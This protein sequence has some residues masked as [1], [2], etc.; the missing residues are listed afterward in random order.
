MS[1]EYDLVVVGGG[2]AGLSAAM[3]GARSGRRV[4]IIAGGLV[5]GQ[6]VS[7]DRIEGIPGF[8]DGIAG[9][10]LCPMAQ[11]QADAAGVEFVASR[12]NSL[13]RTGSQWRLAGDD[14]DLVARALIVATGTS[15]AKLHVPGEDRLQ[16]RGVSECA[17]C[18]A[19]LLRNKIAVVVGGGDSGMQEALTLAD[20]V[21]KVLII[22]RGPALTGQKNYID[23]VTA[24]PKIEF[25]FN[26]AVTE[27]MGED[28][29]SGV[30]IKDNTTGDVLIFDCAAVFVCVG[31]VPN[32]ELVRDILPLDESGRILV[33]SGMRTA[34][35]GICAA[36]N[37]RQ[38]SSHRASGAMGDGAAAA[39]AVNEYLAT[40]YWP[41]AT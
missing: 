34:I 35:P 27:I 13:A 14:G 24:N 8:P 6:L 3:T 29:L 21:A 23:R 4:A 40:G 22:E 18:D 1:R 25:R 7:I 19:P 31:L 32:T 38:S 9:Y 41:S 26:C 28:A 30:Q 2:I 39:V 5:G 20:H 10:D 17:S 15:F 36:G 37:V 16:G 33:D 11:E 12:C